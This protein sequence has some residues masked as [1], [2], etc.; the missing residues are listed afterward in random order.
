[1]SGDTLTA[2]LPARLVCGRK[3]PAP[4]SPGPSA[5][6]PSRRSRWIQGEGV[7]I[8]TE[9]TLLVSLLG[10]CAGGEPSALARFYALTSQ[11]VFTYLLGHADSDQAAE[12]ALVHTYT[13]VWRRVHDFRSTSATPL[14]WTELLAREALEGVAAPGQQ[15]R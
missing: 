2:A 9:D 10:Q 7:A 8:S 11:R 5:R 6:P 4:G 15:R 12:D 1:M 3:R 14:E 13:D